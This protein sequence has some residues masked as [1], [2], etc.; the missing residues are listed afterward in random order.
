LQSDR[1]LARRFADI[2]QELAARGAVE[3]TLQ[4]VVELA[5]RTVDGCEAASVTFIQPGRTVTSLA[6]V[7]EVAEVAD[8]IQYELNEGP[9]LDA[10]R[11][12]APWYLIEDVSDEPRWPK[13][14]ERVKELG[15]GSVLS[16]ALSSPRGMVGALNLY[17]NTPRGFDAAAREVAL[18]YAAHAGVALSA[19]QLEQSLRAAMDSRESIG[20]AMGILMQRHKVGAHQAFEMMAK[21]SQ[22][23]N[24]KLR[25]IADRIVQESQQPAH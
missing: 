9:C 17:A 7:G 11:T 19:V 3:T 4:H 23:T 22:N 1:E 13:F 20:M 21:V 18:I 25:E 12:D 14:A 15:V 24:T 5:T 16:C 10:A 2:A 8:Q 6:C